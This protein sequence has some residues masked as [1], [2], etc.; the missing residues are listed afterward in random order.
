MI[1]LENVT[2]TYRTQAF[3]VNALRGVNLEIEKGELIAITGPS[4][5]GKSTLLHI[6]GCLD[7]PSGGVYRF[8]NSDVQ[9][10][11]DN[12]LAAIR[13]RKIGFVFQFFGLL[14]QI[15]ILRNL[16]IP[17]MFAEVWPPEKRRTMIMDILTE[18]GIANK[19]NF[20]AGD[21]S[22]GE[23]QRVAIARAL[24][25][26]PDLLLTDEPTGN[27]DSVNSEKILSIFRDLN[28]KGMTVIIVTHDEK[29]ARWAKRTI[30]LKD[31][32]IV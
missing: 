17:L 30:V 25:N 11:N 20:A 28:Q 4:G 31:G 1:K 24:I 32:L 12:D 19:A 26:N 18:V 7:R 16:E 3:E 8:E 23:Q 29:V 22:G 13:N 21:V 27:L 9:K 5:S 10:L 2:K 14:P 6:I 15:S